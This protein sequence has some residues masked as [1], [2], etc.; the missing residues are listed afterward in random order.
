MGEKVKAAIL[1]TIMLYGGAPLLQAQSLSVSTGLEA[2]PKPKP[3][4]IPQ[5]L[6]YR[7]FLAWVN[8]LDNKAA[9]AGARDP[10]EFAK[11]FKRASLENSDLDLVRKEA[12]SLDSELTAHDAKA[13]AIIAEYR[14]KAQKAVQ[15]GGPLPPT[16][17]ELHPLQAAR[18][19]MLVQ[20]MIN[21][22]VALGPVKSAQLNSYLQREITPHVSL[23]PL[24][25]SPVSPVTAAQ[26]SFK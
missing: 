18:T 15:S 6:V 10:Y 26:S 21:L 13:K 3:A 22:Q 12:K 23:K 11:P 14:R 7:H 20:H 1:L 5:F 25:H 8:D 9:K 2:L 19:A 17:V 4:V 16:P 24:L